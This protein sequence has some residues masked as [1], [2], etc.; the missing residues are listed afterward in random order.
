MNEQTANILNELTS[1]FYARCADSFSATRERAWHGWE[2]CLD[3]L[4]DELP[5]ESMSVLDIACGN[6]RFESFLAR[7]VPARLDVHAVDSCP[8]LVG[9]GPGIDFHEVDVVVALANRSLLEQLG[10][11]P[12]CDLTCSFGFF[13]HV[14]TPQARRELLDVMLAKTK[15]RRYVLFSLWQLSRDER[16]RAKA[17]ERT[18]RAL[19]ARPSLDLDE[20]DFLLGWQ[21]AD[22][23]LR[24][25]HDFGDAEIADLV[26]HVGS[27]ARVVADFNADGKGGDL[28]RYLVLERLA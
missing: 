28:N 11:V 14:P 24:Y 6:L 23:V 15:P 27:R 22:D 21:D 17:I 16:L 19:E 18:A 26:E 3:A 20:G 7:A 8:Q 2:L 10:D 4:R 13:H 25:C 5:R 12:A 1:D 9:D